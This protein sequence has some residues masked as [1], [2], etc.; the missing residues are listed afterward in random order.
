MIG[1]E[2]YFFDELKDEKAEVIL[3]EF[4]KQYYMQSFNLPHKIMMREVVEDKELIE[5]FLSE[6]A[7]RKVEIKTPQK[8]E[9]LRFV[10]MAEQNA[11]VTLENNQ[12]NNLKH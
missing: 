8:G 1:R 10:E 3:S 7:G 11:K 5:A 4:I 2:H 9:K 6:K 12:K